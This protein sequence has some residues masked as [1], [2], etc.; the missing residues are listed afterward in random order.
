MKRF[1]SLLFWG[2]CTV[3]NAQVDSVKQVQEVV[4]SRGTSNRFRYDLVKPAGTIEQSLKSDSRIDFV[5]RGSYGADILMHGMS[6]ER[7]LVTIDGMRIHSACTDKMDPTTSY[8]DLSNISEININSGGNGRYGNT[9]GGNVD[10]SSQKIQFGTREING[11]VN[12]SLETNNWHSAT[13]ASAIFA[14][15]KV[16]F[17]PTLTFRKASDYKDGNNERINYSSFT[18]YNTSGKLGLKINNQSHIETFALFDQANNVGYPAMPMDTRLAQMFLLA[19]SYVWE[20]KHCDTNYI[21][22]NAKA[23]YNQSKHI[24]D[25]SKRPNVPIRMDMPGQTKT[26]GYVLEINKRWNVKHQLSINVNGFWNQSI[27]EMTMYPANEYPSMY[28]YTWPN[29]HTVNNRVHA[30][31]SWN[32]NTIHQISFSGSLQHQLYTFGDS[33]GY[34]TTTIFHPDV[35][36]TKQ[37]INKSLETKWNIRF[38]QLNI[39]LSANYS[40]R[41]PSISEA[42][43]FYLFNSYDRF[44]YVGDPNLKAEKSFFTHFSIVK[45]LDQNKHLLGFTANYFHIRDY[46]YGRI[47]PGISQ[48]TIGASGVKQYEQLKYANQFD[49]SLFYT[50]SP[51]SWYKLNARIQYNYGV[52]IGTLQLPLIAPLQA[53]LQNNFKYRRNN[54]DVTVN[55]HTRQRDYGAYFGEQETPTWLTIDLGW[56]ATYS[57]KKNKHLL[58]GVVRVENLTNQLYTTYS[59]WNKLPRMGRNFVFK[60]EFTF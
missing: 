41:T 10:L 1:I 42:Y 35:E 56:K 37:H 5:Q 14:R 18:K 9:L 28:M 48:M 53:R 58:T 13:S 2:V 52:G 55:Y 57:L 31:H 12:T 39:R 50:Y 16:Y 40:D 43:G 44:D 6:S 29:I 27:A 25:D 15:P 24:M 4:I 23:Y 34:N 22:V 49:L 17:Q 11:R 36:W 60:I 3:L 8:L 7:T 33:L 30:N 26:A 59:D 47:L 21:N 20:N 45:T 19:Q 54:F 51:N 38:D 32:V 46:I